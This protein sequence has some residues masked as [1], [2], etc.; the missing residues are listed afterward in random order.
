LALYA[1]DAESR[2]YVE[3]SGGNPRNLVL[4]GQESNYG[5]VQNE[6]GPTRYSRFQN[7][8]G[9]TLSNPKLVKNV[10]LKTYDRV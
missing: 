2:K 9:D 6:Y 8:H 1:V 4:G 10:K 5:N 3:H 7:R